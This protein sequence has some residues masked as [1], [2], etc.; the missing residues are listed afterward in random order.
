MFWLQRVKSEMMDMVRSCC[1]ATDQQCLH[2]RI[3]LVRIRSMIVHGR[4][5]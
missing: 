4:L 1:L 2:L 3:Y 5:Q